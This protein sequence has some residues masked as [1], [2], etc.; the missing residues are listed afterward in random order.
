M[1]AL[2]YRYLQTVLLG[3]AF[4]LCS[5]SVSAQDRR[6][7]GKIT[8]VDGPV[9]GANIVLKGT[10]TGTS[11][12]A[13]GNYSLSVRGTDPVLVISSIGAKTQEV[14]IGNRSVVDVTM[15]DD[16]TSL[17][18]VVVTGY[19]TENRRDVT[20]AV[21]T[22]KP[23]QLKVVPSTNVEQQLQ[24]RVAG[25][26]VITNG[27][28]GTTSQVRVRGFGSFGGNQPLYVVDGVPTQTAQ[29]I[30]PDDI[31]TTTILK[32]AASASIYGARAAAG[33]IV[34]TTKKGQRRA[35]KLSVSYDGLYGVTDPGKSLPILN[36]QEQADWTWQARKN[37]IYQAGGTVGPDSFTGLA[38]GQFG[39]GQNPVLPD[40]LLA[41]KSSGLAASAVNLSAEALKYNIDRSRGDIYLV[42]PSDKQG[43]DWY[44]AITRTAPLTRHT[45]GFS[46]GSESSRY[47]VSVGMQNQAGI[48]TNNNFSRYNFRVNTEFDITKKLRFGENIQFAYVSATGL[49]STLR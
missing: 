1:K 39:S 16:A 13:N 6:V 31:E 24:G 34:L 2:L 18:E 20:G 37:D 42:I 46:G 9:P 15:E 43:T 30:A 17:S 47:Y 33:V 21:S 3:T 25:V 7:T 29:F 49:Q 48:I 11:S 38:S 36:P 12:D 4:L 32:D 8:G 19:S 35:Q 40:Y 22:V 14:A 27:Q 41:G 5:L 10:Q 28:P 44:K 23:A 26:T 45:L